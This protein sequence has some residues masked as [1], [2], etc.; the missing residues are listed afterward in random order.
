M[1]VLFGIL[2][3][4]GLI[5]LVAWCIKGGNVSFGILI[6]SLWWVLVSWIG[7]KL[8]SPEFILANEEA[9]SKSPVGPDKAGLPDRP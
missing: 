5:F 3:F 1:E 4:L 2:V 9:A 6:A 8:A 7:F